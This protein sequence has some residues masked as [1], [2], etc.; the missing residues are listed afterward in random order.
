MNDS[1]GVF[2]GVFEL[3][4]TALLPTKV[5]REMCKAIESAGDE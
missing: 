2:V 3:D 1:D 5:I 4:V